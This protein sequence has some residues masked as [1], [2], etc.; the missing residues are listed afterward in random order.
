MP[1]MKIR[2]IAIYTIFFLKFLPWNQLANLSQAWP[3]LSLGIFWCVEGSVTQ[4]HDVFMVTLHRN[5]ACWWGL[6]LN[7]ILMG[8]VTQDSDVGLGCFTV[9][10]CVCGSVTQNS[11]VFRFKLHSFLMCSG[12]SYTCKIQVYLVFSYTGFRCIQ[13]SVTLKA[14]I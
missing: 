8:S 12:F 4:H 6:M 10:W 1:I 2:H 3:E 13:C 14:K 7:R 11:G 5:L 9:C